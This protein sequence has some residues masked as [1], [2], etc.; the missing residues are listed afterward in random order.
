MGESPSRSKL[1]EPLL[2]LD[3]PDLL[4]ADLVG[5]TVEETAAEED[6][7]AGA[8]AAATAAA[9]LLGAAGL[10]AAAAAEAAAGLVELL[11]GLAEAAGAPARSAYEDMVIHHFNKEGKGT[12]EQNEMVSR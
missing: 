1:S 3:E 5:G 7:E 9:A 11:L 4:E 10:A 2:D 12:I 6:L 8:A